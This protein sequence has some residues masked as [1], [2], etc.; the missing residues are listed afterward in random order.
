[1]DE[2]NKQLSVGLPYEWA[3]KKVLGPTLDQLGL[4]VGK[5]Y[6]AGRDR[7]IEAARNKIKNI[8]DSA[9]AN[10][11][12][13]RDV[14]LNGAF[15]DEAICAEYF[16]GILAASRS[17]DGKDDTGIFYTDIIKS[18]SSSQLHLHYVIYQCL[19]KLLVADETKKNLNVGLGTDIQTLEIYFNTIELTYLGLK[20]DTDLEALFR[21]GLL[22]KYANN[23]EK[24]SDEGV[25]QFTQAGPT[26]LGVQL[27][28]IANNDL[29]NWRGYPFSEYNDFENIALPQYYEFNLEGLKNVFSAKPSADDGDIG[30]K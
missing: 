8:E 19:N 3:F 25:L 13:S 18:L 4:D 29:S 21:K 23:A 6:Q 17:K 14:F 30:K 11:R 28:M 20:I 5:I 12:V 24:I 1:M 2:E 15:T 9:K 10:L 27:F 16:G 7:I 26:T 22:I